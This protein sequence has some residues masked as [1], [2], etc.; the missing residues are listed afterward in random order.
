L[1]G[2]MSTSPLKTTA[3][4]LFYRIIAAAFLGAGAFLLVVTYLP[5][6][7]PKLFEY[8]TDERGR[9]IHIMLSQIGEHAQPLSYYLIGTPLSLLLLWAACHF[10]I[11]AME[12][13]GELE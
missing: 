8:A 12:L 6:L 9:I 13:G 10:N 5:V 3:K 7:N 1:A 4:L 2:G 11:K